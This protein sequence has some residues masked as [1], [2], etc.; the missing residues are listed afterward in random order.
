MISALRVYFSLL[1]I[2]ITGHRELS[3]IHPIA[4]GSAIG[5]IADGAY[6][7]LVIAAGIRVC[8]EVNGIAPAVHNRGGRPGPGSRVGRPLHLVAVGRFNTVAIHI[9]LPAH[10][11][12]WEDG[13]YHLQVN[14]RTANRIGHLVQRI[15]FC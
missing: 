2:M 14:G 1:P 7:P 11:K 4:V 13:T 8:A 12:G 15:G 9:Y 5:G 6:P 10:A 3:A